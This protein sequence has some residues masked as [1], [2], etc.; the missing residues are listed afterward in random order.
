MIDAY[1]VSCYE[2][3]EVGDIAETRCPYCGQYWN[4]PRSPKPLCRPTESNVIIN[5]TRRY[6]KDRGIVDIPIL[7]KIDRVAVDNSYTDI[8]EKLTN[9]ELEAARYKI[10]QILKQKD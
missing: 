8:R 4:V 2:C 7:Y 6:I 1:Q 9:L 3:G 5:D 10:I